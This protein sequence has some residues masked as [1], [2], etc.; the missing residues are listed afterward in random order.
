MTLFV[1]A[2][3]RYGRA[4]MDQQVL[5]GSDL[6]RITYYLAPGLGLARQ[7]VKN[8][9]EIDSSND[10]PP[11]LL[12]SEVVELQFR[13][14]DGSSQQWMTSWDGTTTGPPFAVEVTL[15]ILAQPEAGTLATST[16]SI[17]YYRAVVSIPTASLSQSSSSSGGQSGGTQ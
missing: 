15:G 12:A 14:F 8:V 3:P 4:D 2:V 7:E 11:D 16:G 17:A 9:T 1:S 5:N 10:L 6:R 13:Y